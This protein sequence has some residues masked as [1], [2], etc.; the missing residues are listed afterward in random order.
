M[1]MKDKIA[2]L[3]KQLESA[4]RHTY[5]YDTHTMHCSDGEFYVEYGD[6]PDSKTLVWN[7]DDMFNSLSFI[8]RQV[9]K[10]KAKMYKW[11]LDNIKDSIKE[12]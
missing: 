7:I 6:Y 10:E 11:R 4:K 3:E 8:V 1:K 5:I 12:L 2:D 9:T